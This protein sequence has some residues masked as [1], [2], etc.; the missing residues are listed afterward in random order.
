MDGFSRFWNGRPYTKV[1]KTYAKLTKQL[2]L[3]NKRWM[4]LSDMAKLIRGKIGPKHARKA[5]DPYEN[6]S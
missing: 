3:A 1:T 4:K 2:V 6:C 5:N